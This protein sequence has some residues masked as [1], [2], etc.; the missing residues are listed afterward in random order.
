MTTDHADS[1][2]RCIATA[3]HDGGH[4]FASTDCIANP[5]DRGERCPT[6]LTPE[7]PPARE[8]GWYWAKLIDNPTHWRAVFFDA[9]V[10]CSAWTWPMPTSGVVEWGPRIDPPGQPAELPPLPDGW[11]W[12]HDRYVK[13]RWVIRMTRD[14]EV[15]VQE[16][17][18]C[19]DAPAAVLRHL[20]GLT[21]PAADVRALER[22]K[23]YQGSCW[24]S[25]CEGA[26]E[27]TPCE[28]CGAEEYTGPARLVTRSY[29]VM[30]LTGK[31]APL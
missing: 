31:G 19:I 5:E 27:E 9:D 11:R 4:L 7:A 14:G 17:G 30:G 15:R 13:D 10:V 16:G 6:T 28:R 25:D 24:C 18:W 2:Q 1:P 8:P 23:L 20:L 12:E 3:G 22:P 21:A 29:W 26:L